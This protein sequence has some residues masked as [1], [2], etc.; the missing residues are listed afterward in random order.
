MRSSGKGIGRPLWPE[1]SPARTTSLNG[2]VEQFSV[3]HVAAGYGRCM[4]RSASI[5]RAGNFEAGPGGRVPP[6]QRQALNLGVV[7]EYSEMNE[8][9]LKDNT[10]SAE[11]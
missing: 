8:A 11:R 1:R 7:L 3:M 9:P 6:D 4:L 10:S 2:S 5:L